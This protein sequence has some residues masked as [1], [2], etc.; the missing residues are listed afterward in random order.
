MFGYEEVSLNLTYPLIYLFLALILIAGY[1]YYVYRYTIPP[2]NK[3]RKIL[4]VTLRALALLLLCF[5]LFEPILNLNRKLNLEPSNLVFIDNSRSMT[6]EDG[7]KRSLNSK[8][9]LNYLLNNASQNN[10]LFY[11]FG[12]SVR[13]VNPD[14][15]DRVN[16]SDG[17][18]NLQDVFNYAKNSDK[19]IASVTLITD[20]V[21]TSGSNPYYE[22]INIG[23]PLFTIGIGDTTQRKDVEIKKIL[24]NDYLYAETPTSIIA[25]IYN[26]GFAGEIVTA[27]LYEDNRF[28][29]QQNVILS[30][31]GIQNVT[32]DYKPE[33]SGEKKLSIAV[34]PLKNEFTDANNKKIFYV[35]VLSNKIKVVLF[36]S[37]PSSDLTFIKDAL[38]RDENF[39]VN[40]IVQIAPEK[41]LDK[42]NYQLIDSAE[43]F[44]LIGFPS[45]QTPGNLL[46]RVTS[47]IKNEK[48]P[49][50]LTLSPD[51]SLNR[52]SALGN[53][54]SFTINQAMNGY[55]EVQ[56][57]IIIE[58]SD[59]PI[60]K[61]DDKNLTELW[62]NLPP[63]LQPNFT[64]T[65]KIESKMLA[66]IKMNN[67][68]LNIP[69]I[70]TKNFSGKRSVTVLAKDIWKW[71]LQVAPKGIE[72]FD[73]FIVNSLRW[74][75]AGEEQKLVSIKS[76]KKNYSQGEKIEFSA[77]VSDESLNP[78]SDAEIK[79]KINSD[80]N[81]Y[82]TEMQNVGPGL[83]EGSILIN[84]TGDFRY[85]GEALSNGRLLGKDNGSFNIGEIDLE[86]VN[87]VM[88][89]SLLKLIA[90]E[91]GGEF[92]SPENY[93][94]VIT[95][96]GELN[97]ISSKEKILKSEITLWSDTWMLIAAIILFSLEWFIRK[98]SGML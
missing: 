18:T 53:D 98:R 19:N 39:E 95:K 34:T 86:M 41:F 63:V 27:S 29:S 92:Y 4:L 12:N 35:N 66:E 49:Y 72:L 64:I 65:P 43:V 54:L 47:R 79:I 78:V 77:Q 87:P 36:A 7:T 46:N 73:N 76:S 15:L 30:S 48:I 14:S 26:K 68:V 90:D 71:K 82:E 96:I 81:E 89:Y 93:K 91:S 3:S 88:N 9:I 51:I 38:K 61:Q 42:L 69:L 10:L 32:F 20:G 16:F 85:S 44:M 62:N 24:N 97:R 75:K 60:L 17:S 13:D 52:L 70:L 1:S 40:S 33:K 50:F 2:V 6:I 74:L 23:V 58:Q 11:E 59:N 31:A 55:R 80:K 45:N 5:I 21:I 8:E 28:I 83:Y 56:P 84:Q 67:N 25:T 57:Q 37:S 94:S 22:A